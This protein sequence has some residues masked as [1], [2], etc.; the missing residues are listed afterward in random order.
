MSPKSYLKTPPPNKFWH[1]F[2]YLIVGG[3]LLTYYAFFNGFPIMYADTGSYIN[4]GFE[5]TV[6]KAH[7]ITYGWFLRHISMKATLW[8]VVLFQG[9]TLAYLIEK[10]F[11]QFT[12]V[13]Y[14]H[15]VS[16]LTIIFLVLFTGVSVYSSM[17]MPDIFSAFLIISLC[18]LLFAE[19]L[20]THSKIII[21]L[22]FIYAITVHNSSFLS[23]AIVLLA[24]GCFYW[25]K[26]KWRSKSRWQ[27]LILSTLLLITAWVSVPAIHQSLGSTFS[28]ARYPHVF[29]MAR[30]AENGVLN[31]YLED[32]CPDDNYALCDEKNRIPKSA[33][34][35]IWSPTSPFIRTGWWH[36]SKPEYDA[37]IYGTLTDPKYLKMYV[38]ASTHATL[39][40]FFTYSV[41]DGLGKM[42]PHKSTSNA[43]RIRFP[44]EYRTYMR[45]LQ[46]K[47]KLDFEELS[48]YQHFFIFGAVLI[49]ALFLMYPAVKELLTPSQKLLLFT[50][51]MGLFANAFVCGTF[52]NVVPRLQGRIAWIIPL[53]AVLLLAD[54][55]KRGYVHF[56]QQLNLSSEHTKN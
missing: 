7:T 3:I 44:H 42:H 41:G 32:H 38:I 33:I 40:Q 19:K 5:N 13:K 18:L 43:I 47:G 9:V 6:P 26:K 54:H 24:V 39:Q 8:V 23:T 14:T 28:T 25:R 31:T 22:V 2:L 1:H 11:S 35:F 27:S 15:L 52:A 34:E 17:L 49:L 50:F 45:S 29:I 10:L 16:L 53:L 37:I 20:K 51:F 36:K 4:T 48:K 56:K 46:Q 30:M 55:F 12:Q 21:A